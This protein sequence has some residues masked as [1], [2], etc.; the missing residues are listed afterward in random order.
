MHLHVWV[1]R[2]MSPIATSC[3]VFACVFG[4]ALLGMLLRKVLPEHH[5]DPDSRSIVNSG[6]A[7]IGTMSALLLSLLIASAKSSFDAQRGEITQMSADIIQLDRVLGRYGPEANLARTALRRMVIAA[8]QSWSQGSS[9][10]E[11]LDSAEIRVGVAS[12]YEKVEELTPH[13]DFQRQLQSQALQ[14]GAELGRTRSLLLE[15]AGSAISLPFLVVMVFWLSVIFTS[16]GLFSP[17]N[18]TVI[19]TLLVCALSVSGAIFLILE[20]DS[21]FSGLLQISDAPLRSA[22]AHIGQ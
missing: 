17:R 1:S 7:L 15:Q 14:M 11:W 2:D 20:L 3:I 4:G 16:F 13:N 12:L 18:T 6:M 9:R 19:A 8:D 10:S 22:I 21:P 5:L